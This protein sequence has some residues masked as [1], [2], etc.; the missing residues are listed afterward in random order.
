MRILQVT[1]RYHPRTGGVETH[2]R[3][4]S[5]RLVDRGHDVTV[6]TADAGEGVDRRETIDGV[7]VRRYRAFSP[8]GNFHV[9]PGMVRGVRESD[10]DVVHA[11][12]YHSFPLPFAALGVREERFVVTPHYHGGSASAVRARLLALYRPLGRRAVGRA[13]AVVA[14][15]GWERDLLRENL[16]VDATVIPNGLDVDRF[17][18]APPEDRERPYLLCVGRLVEYKGV[19]HAIAALSDL[20]GYELVVVG[21]GPHRGALEALAEDRGVERRVTFLGHVADQRLPGLYAGAGVHLNLSTQEA[22]GM[23]VAEALAA[24]TPC[25]VRETAALVEWTET[26]GA[27]GV[28]TDDADVVAAAVREAESLRP[29]ASLPSWE[30]VCDDLLSVYGTAPRAQRD[31]RR[32]GPP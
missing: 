21:D 25:V 27:V 14:V 15:S 9:A 20:P 4:V 32:S 28:P 2:V 29:S 16:G 13:D 22:Y 11:H 24:G 12:N 31:A 26:H 5:E 10:A 30:T 8:G 6:M 17:A 18:A 7:S 3:E 1:P 23:T 19:Q